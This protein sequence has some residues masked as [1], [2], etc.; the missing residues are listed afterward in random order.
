MQ[1]GILTS[2]P[3]LTEEAFKYPMFGVVNW[4]LVCLIGNTVSLGQSTDMTIVFSSTNVY[5]SFQY[6]STRMGFYDYVLFMLMLYVIMEL[7]S[8]FNFWNLY[9][10]YIFE[11]VIYISKVFVYLRI[12]YATFGYVFQ[13]LSCFT[14]WVVFNYFVNFY[15]F[16]RTQGLNIVRYLKSFLVICL[17]LCE[18]MR[19]QPRSAH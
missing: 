1:W 5:D 8:N 11:N 12:K 9:P 7:W 4:Y 15:N 10:V 6:K 17:N 2:I 3:C 19:G 13:Y 18:V 16:G 14:E